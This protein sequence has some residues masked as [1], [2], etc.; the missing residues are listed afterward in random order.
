MATAISLPTKILDHSAEV[1]LDCD[2]ATHCHWFEKNGIASTSCANR[3]SMICH[4]RL[5][6]VFSPHQRA[7]PKPNV[8]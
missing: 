4:K 8:D 5:D 1:R 2:E 7:H 3:D 6:D